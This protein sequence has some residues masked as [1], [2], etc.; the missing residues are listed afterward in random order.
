MPGASPDPPP[1]PIP[2]AAPAPTPPPALASPFDVFLSYNRQDHA[3]AT[4]IADALRARGLHP[5]IDV[6]EL[7]PG[8]RWQDALEQ[9]LGHVRTT[10]VLVGG[11][12]LGPWQVPEMRAAIGESVRRGLPVIPVLLPGAPDRPALPLFLRDFTWVD[13]RHGLTPDDLDQLHWGITGV[14]AGSGSAPAPWAPRGPARHNLPFLS[15]GALFTGREQELLYL[16]ADIGDAAAAITQDQVLCGL[17]GM[18]KSR[19]AVEYAWRYG[20]RYNA[21]L[22]V[23]ADSRGSLRRGLAALAAAD[24]LDLPERQAPHEDETVAAVLR[25]LGESPGWLLILDN[26]DSLE[27]A[28]AVSELLPRLASGRVLITAR[29]THWGP[30]LAGQPLAPLAPAEAASFLDRWTAG[31]R[32]PRPDDPQAAERLAAIL[33]GLR[34]VR[35]RRVRRRLARVRVGDVRV[36][37]RPV[38]RDLDDRIAAGLAAAGAAAVGIQRADGKASVAGI[39]IGAQVTAAAAAGAVR[40]RAFPAGAVV[41]GP[42]ATTRSRGVRF[43]GRQRACCMEQQQ[44]DDG[45][46]QPPGRKRPPAPHGASPAAAVANSAR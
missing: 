1:A 6:T 16:A 2:S 44:A 8:R 33:G 29:W 21:V 4:K 31:R 25:R 28:A 22:F 5:W 42:Q 34:A 20:G 19:L 13:L 14:K 45:R 46:R 10:A 23:S 27:A 43:A 32:S 41:G 35:R 17:G 37:R 39:V 36:G 7:I 11:D 12:G 24:L 38:G 15:L 40:L 18:G 3:Q 26:A 9:A 30:A